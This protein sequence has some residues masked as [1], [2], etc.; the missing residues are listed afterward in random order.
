[1]AAVFGRTRWKRFAVI[2][3]P[4]LAVTA[5]LG[6]SMAQGALAASFFISGDEFKIA[7]ESIS[8]RGLSIYG[9]VDTTRQGT[10]VP[11][12]VAGF[13]A[14][15]VRG[16]CQSV[17][18]PIPVLGPY[19]LRLTAADRG[20]PAEASGLF[21]DASALAAAHAT[22]SN[23][24]IGIAAGSL[25]TGPVSPQDR[26]SPFFDPNS[27]AQQGSSTT[28]TGVR[29]NAVALSAGTFDLPGLGVVLNKGLT[30]CF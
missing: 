19:T 6:L 16:L 8:A 3:V 21:I 22:I 27:V 7:S 30:E 24:D 23:L 28:L 29:V 18:V 9:T 4:S 20:E 13:R 11:V 14:A 10:H 12:V 1:M 5:A 17:V 26:D 25:T 2:L 15:R